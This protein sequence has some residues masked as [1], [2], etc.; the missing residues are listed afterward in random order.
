MMREPETAMYEKVDGFVGFS[1]K[2]MV[3]NDEG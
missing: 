3:L 2:F 1:Q